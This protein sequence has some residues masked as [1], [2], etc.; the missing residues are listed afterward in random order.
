MW[1]INPLTGQI[2]AMCRLGLRNLLPQV[3]GAR[4]EVFVNSAKMVF[5]D[6]LMASVNISAR[7]GGAQGGHMRRQLIAQQGSA[8]PKT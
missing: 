4:L 3:F 1:G 5:D 8:S 6:M 2:V 7:T